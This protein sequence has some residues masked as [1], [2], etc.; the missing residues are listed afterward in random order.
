M[1]GSFAKETLDRNERERNY[2]I[3]N[4]ELDGALGCLQV[5]LLEDCQQGKQNDNWA[6]I[7]DLPLEMAAIRFVGA[8]ARGRDSSQVV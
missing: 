2:Q 3:G 5:G 1:P 6:R 8:H 4:Q 7:D